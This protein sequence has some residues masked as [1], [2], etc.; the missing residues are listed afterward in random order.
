MKHG[1]HA[2]AHVAGRADSAAMDWGVGRYES[3]A[4]Q[5]LPAARVVVDTAA[6]RPAERALDLGCGTGNAALLAAELC[7]EVIGVD[8]AQRLLDVARARAASEAREVT[9]LHG[10][11][12][13]LPIDDSSVDAILSVFAV[14]FAPDPG[15][16]AAE[17]SRVLAPGGRIVLSAWIPAGALFELNSVAAETVRQAVGAPPMPAPFAWH[18]RDWLLSLLAPYGFGVDIQPHSL[19]FA[20]SSAQ[21]FLDIEARNHPLAVAGL[22]VLEPLGQADALR[23]RLLGILEKGNE[24]R[25]SFRVTSRYVVAA[26]R[27]AG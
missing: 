20:A 13:S 15:A 19:T 5:L 25:D 16:A 24:D 7:G 4:E 11:A 22:R 9:F 18:D 8:P 12:A 26:A 23:A 1:D 2:G 14:I 3:T 6:I 17:M 27:R 10:E 21:E